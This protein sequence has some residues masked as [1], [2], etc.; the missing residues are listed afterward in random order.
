[1]L[2]AT[3]GQRQCNE[4]ANHK[5]EYLSIS[6]QDLGSDGVGRGDVVLPV[7]LIVMETEERFTDMTGCVPS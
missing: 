6:A 2:Q 3:K 1:M 7:D 5:D 4:S